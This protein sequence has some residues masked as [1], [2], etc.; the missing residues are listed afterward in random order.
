MIRSA[1]AWFADL[2]ITVTLAVFGSVAA[3]LITSALIVWIRGY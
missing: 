3:F 2:A 1:I